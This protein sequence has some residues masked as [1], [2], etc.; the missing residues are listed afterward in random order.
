MSA[1]TFRKCRDSGR[2]YVIAEIGVNHDGNLKKALALVLAAA[3]C[4]AD[5]VKI[6]T[7]SA[8]R[9]ALP[10]AKKAD[11]QKLATGG[12]GSQFEMLKKLELGL[13]DHLA[14]RD[15][16]EEL[17]ID[18]FS[19]PYDVASLEFLVQELNVPIVKI[20]S[21]DLVNTP[22]LVAAGRCNR[23]TILSTGMSTL[24]EIERAIAAFAYGAL[25]RFPN[26]GPKFADLESFDVLDWSSSR[27]SGRLSLMQ[28]TSE[29]PTP[30]DHSNVFAIPALASRTGLAI[31]YSDHTRTNTAATMA[32]ALGAPVIEKHLT[33]N[34]L[35]VGPDHMASLDPDAMRS[36]IAQIREAELCRGTGIKEPS[37]VEVGNKSHMRTGLY[38]TRTIRAGEVISEEDVQVARPATDLSPEHYWDVVGMRAPR[39]IGFGDPV[40]LAD[41]NA[42]GVV[43]MP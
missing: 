21:A 19:T 41:G 40:F 2:V 14:L 12:S 9:L 17:G 22:L 37:V 8:T 15:Y 16:A 6:Q 29:Y 11:Y 31:G 23:D 18:F 28:C 3:E 30:L 42:D 7:F 4:G 10:R 38:A 13:Q 35:D 24:E 32:V 26:S 39:D 20:S 27:V 33:L 25:E 36:Y 43:K 5:A 34:R 1:D